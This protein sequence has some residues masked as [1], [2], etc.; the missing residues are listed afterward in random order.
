MKAKDKYEDMNKE[1]CGRVVF[2]KE[3]GIIHSYTLECGYH[4]NI[5]DNVL[6]EPADT[7]KIYRL[8]P[9]WTH[10]GHQKLFEKEVPIK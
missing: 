5:Q 3:F 9:R 1:G 6:K 7:N 8:R 4:C 2:Y 10:N